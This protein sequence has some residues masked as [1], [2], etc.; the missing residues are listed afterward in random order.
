M[1]TLMTTVIDDAIIL[2]VIARA[3]DEYTG[4]KEIT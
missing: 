2:E 4:E 3:M 1:S